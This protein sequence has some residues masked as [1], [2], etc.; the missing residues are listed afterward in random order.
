MRK[1][2][3][4]VKAY[5][6]AHKVITV[7]ILIVALSIGYWGYKK[8]TSTALENRYII[9]KVERGAIVASV[10]GT[11]QVSALNQIDIKAKA[12]GDVL[13]LPGQ[14]GERVSASDLLAELDTKDAMKAVRDAETSLASAQI[15]LN[16]L[17]I[18]ES[19]EN[20]NANL[21]KSY[22]DGFNTVSN[23]FLDLPGI[24]TALNDMF[25]KSTIG[26][27][28]W[29]VDWL[30]EQVVSADR[31]QALLY[32]QTFTKSYNKALSAYN[33]SALS[34]NSVSRS[35][36]PESIETFISES[37]D[38]TKEIANSVKDAH[39]YLDF[40]NDS[41]K[42]NNFTM[43]AILT[44][45]KNN[46]NTYT[47]E[48]NTD[49]TNLLATTTNIKTNKDA[50]PNSTLDMQSAELA[51]TQ[52]E[53]A[54]QDAKDKLADYYIR[55]PFAGT[56][57]VVN[58]KKSDSISSGSVVATLI[59]E[60]Q[61]AEISL[62]EVDEAKVNIGEKATLTFDALPGLTI[63]G[64]VSEI[65]SV[66][67]VSQGVVT[68]IAKISFATEDKK[69]KTGMSVSAA[70]I[71]DIKQ[72][73]LMVPNS[74]VRSQGGTEYVENFDIPLPAPTDGL[75]GSISKIAPNR[76]PVQT[77]LANDSKTEIVSGMKEGEE[78][79]IRTILPTAAKTTA[80][81]IFGG[82]GTGRI[83]RGN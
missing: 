23:V 27:G 46:L 47:A 42:R 75:I 7:V 50:F 62:N 81:S 10:S 52:K 54:L 35:S 6:V 16:K 34:Y 26:T 45:Y 14:N 38:T 22:D 76:I 83:Q 15:A 63:T 61:L 51:I 67:T 60:K 41:I 2:I 57:A 48:T 31:D 82:G 29:N 66:G 69:V 59:T 79:I 3:N 56:V 32:K 53:N 70:I 30:A 1:H 12:S 8:I 71:T 80:P 78:I 73:V 11:G 25:F 43:P 37:Y 21:A 24:M 49:L 18:Q 58:I 40:V 65:D 13:Y 55:A 20:M 9:G 68:Y 5:I 17:K 36:L 4:V 72:N 64:V 74:A 77:G 44:T 39:N 19:A 28:Q 33:A